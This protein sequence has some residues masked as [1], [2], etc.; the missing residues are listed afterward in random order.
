M[1]ATA[2][3]STALP[4]SF[5]DYILRARA[6]AA[7]KGSG[8]AVGVVELVP[9]RPGGRLSEQRA[10]GAEAVERLSRTLRQT[11]GVVRRGARQLLFLAEEVGP[12][13]LEALGNRV[14][15]ALSDPMG[16]AREPVAAVPAVGMAL[17]TSPSDA[18][19]SLL[20]AADQALLEAKR[21][22]GNRWQ[23]AEL[24][25]AGSTTAVAD[26]AT[27]PGSAPAARLSVLQRSVG[28]FSLGALVWVVANYTGIT[29][30]EALA[31]QSRCL[32]ESANTRTKALAE[33]GR[34]FAKEIQRSVGPL[35]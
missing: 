2:L 15:R 35:R 24:P 18:P 16:G 9:A 13:E 1:V 20:K 6:R 5:D 14:V 11:D 25:D 3:A 32:V 34:R 23:A 22:G 8:F 33:Q 7:R 31:Q 12:H 28:W 30:A 4:P 10:C 26:Q 29:S 27:S 19:D 17:W 21:R